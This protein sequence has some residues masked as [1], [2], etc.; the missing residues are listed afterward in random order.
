MK[1]LY[2]LLR[3]KPAR[4]DFGV[5]VECE[6]ENIN[7][8][9]PVGW[10]AVDDGSL[11]GV[12]PHGRCEFVFTQPASLKTTIKRV[13][14]L[15]EAQKDAK[16]NFSFRTSVHVHVNCQAL[17]WNEYCAFIYASLLLEG[18]LSQY[19]GEGRINNRFCLRVAD[20]EMIVA[21]I[22]RVF[23]GGPDMMRVMRDGEVRYG[24][25]N[26]AATNKYGSLEFRGM[27]GTL[28]TKVLETWITALYNIRS[29]AQEAGS[30]HKVHDLFV[31]MSPEDFIVAALGESAKEMYFD[32]G[33][34][35]VRKSFSLTLEL[36]YQF[37]PYK[38]LEAAPLQIPKIVRFNDVP[39]PDMW[40]RI[41]EVGNVNAEVQILRRRV[42]P[43]APRPVMDPDGNLIHDF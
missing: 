11:R 39:A 24:F 6:G 7:S 26:M 2:E 20:A 23:E 21:N 17:T 16:L 10:K 5:E 28:D 41:G 40:A 32:G 4:G 35:E 8:D 12:F 18:V 19:C 22:R 42:L 33:V 37:H 27:R 15:A 34:A 3:L 31:K 14:E 38:E 29:F 13:N 1:K 25:I 9:C 36:P 43:A 30:P